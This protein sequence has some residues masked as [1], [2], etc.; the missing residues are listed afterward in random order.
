MGEVYRARDSRLGRTVAIKV[1]SAETE[2]QRTRLEREARAVARLNHPHICALYDVGHQEGLTYLVMEYLEG[3]T[4]AAQLESGPLPLPRALAIGIEIA[5]ALAAAHDRGVTHRDLKPSNVM[6][7]SDGA[8]LLDF[9]L[10][11]LGHTDD[12]PNSPAPTASLG[13][14]ESGTVLGTYPYMAPEQVEG[15]DADARTDIFAFGVLLHEM[16]SGQ[17]PFEARTHA[18]LAAAILTREPPPLSTLCPAATPALE[19]ALAKCLAKDRDARWQ[20][21]RDLASELRWIS[22]G[23]PDRP[24]R[25]AAP[26]WRPP[27]KAPAWA[28]AGALVG[29]LAIGGLLL[30]RAPATRLETPAFLRVTF[31]RGIVPSARFAPDGETLIYSAAWYGQPYETFETRIGSGEARSLGFRNRNLAAVS[32]S[33][34]LALIVDQRGY[35]RPPG[36]L[37]HAPLN[38]A[39]T[40][41]PLLDDVR[42]ADWIPGGNELAVVRRLGALD[43]LEFPMGRKVHEAPTMQAL[44]VSPNGDLVAILEGADATGENV[45]VTIV[46]RSG[47]RTV[48]SPNWRVAD[49]LA[50]SP[51]GNEVWFSASRGVAAASVQA[52]TLSGTERALFHAPLSLHV[53]DVSRSGRVLFTM[54]DGRDSISCLSPNGFGERDLS[55]LDGSSVRSISAQGSLVLFTEERAGG[56]GAG[57]TYLRPADGSPPSRLG[58]GLAEALSPDERWALTAA[59]GRRNWVLWP[60][61]SGT[62]RVL[63]TGD[64]A[65]VGTGGWTADSRRIVFSA[66]DSKGRQRVYM[67][68]I[69]EGLPRPV[70][71]DGYA[72]ALGA[73]GPDGRF[74]VRD[75]DGRHFLLSESGSV[76]ALPALDGTPLQWS[77]DANILFV[78]RGHVP[79]EIHR[80]DIATGR[81][82]RW[83]TLLPSDPDGVERILPIVITPDGRSYCYS[84]RRTITNLFVTAVAVK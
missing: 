8:K 31:Q 49:G 45:S 69:D 26:R 3:E 12:D 22:E 28:G 14:T 27:W 11:K 48:L 39:V 54:L 44:R 56:A 7:T 1:L 75:S 78:R 64:F 68:R 2:R 81:A 19:R 79:A 74:A 35:E 4:L 37:V 21:A 65:R 10:A 57:M 83:E 73:S 23:K 60:T 52:V 63:P 55:W 59:N 46:D 51:D 47:M 71:P 29:V 34:E 41:R 58:E 18:G 53:Q 13:E 50:W 20:T 84:Y 62:K 5:E 40:P 17:R 30:G 25:R 67:Q 66:F 82:E 42:E 61:G 16:A 6:V 43:V 77:S 76:Q 80:L 9:G 32:G 33:G 36:T 15:L 72:L 38:S 70:G 24:M